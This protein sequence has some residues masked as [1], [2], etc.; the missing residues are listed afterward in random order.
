MESGTTYPNDA[1]L[2]QYYPI[3]TDDEW[4]VQYLNDILETLNMRMEIPGFNENESKEM[5]TYLCIS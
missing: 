5:R 4:K 2:L 3:S 1:F